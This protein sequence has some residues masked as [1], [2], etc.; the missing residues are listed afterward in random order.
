[1]LASTCIAQQEYAQTE[2][3]LNAVTDS[4]P[5]SPTTAQWIAWRACAELELARRH[6]ENALQI[7]DQ[8]IASAH[9]EQG[10]VIPCLWHLRG[11]ALSAC[12]RKA[13]AEAVLQAAHAT[14]QVQGTRPMLWRIC[15]T[16]GK[17]SAMQG[18]REQAR[19]L[20]T[21]A[22]TIIEELASQ[23]ADDAVRANYLRCTTAQIP[24][25]P[26]RSP[27][28]AVKHLFGG[29]TERERDVERLVA[30]GKSNRALADELIV[31]ER[32]IEKHV[33][34]IMSKLGF[35]SRVQIAAW[36]VET[37]VMKHSD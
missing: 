21:E 5:L 25:L 8:L 12:D 29:F 7:L 9:I 14:A 16:L 15:V 2:A 18:R 31:S 36:A 34:R 20:F 33:E 32:T 10:L 26:E 22:R 30:Q 24:R 28:R 6:P 37:G 11:E 1:L 27:R 35:S 3:V 4:L 19:V 17:L 23:V 13:E